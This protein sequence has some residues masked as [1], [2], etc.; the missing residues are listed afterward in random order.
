MRRVVV[1]LTALILGVIMTLLTAWVLPRFGPIRIVTKAPA[2]NI[3]LLDR[4]HH[5]VGV[6]ANDP[7][8]KTFGR[9]QFTGWAYEREVIYATDGTNNRTIRR[10]RCGWPFL[11]MHGS[12]T[13]VIGMENMAD[14]RHIPL[15]GRPNRIFGPFLPV[16]F[17]LPGFIANTMLYA[18]VALSLIQLPG[19]VRTVRRRRRGQCTVCGYPI[20]TSAT[21]TECGRAV[22]K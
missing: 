19:H 16:G 5:A 8:L 12:E 14:A 9:Q 11:A 1:I 3:E 10:C 4:T 7:L 6:L 21:C 18:L 22:C 13:T 20:G 2:S 17:L 15:L